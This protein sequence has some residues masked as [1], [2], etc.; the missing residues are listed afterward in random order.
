MRCGSGAGLFTYKLSDKPFD[1]NLYLRVDGE[2]KKHCDGADRT[3][4]HSGDGAKCALKWSDESKRCGD[5]V[6]LL[7]QTD[8]YDFFLGT[9]TKKFPSPRQC[10]KCFGTTKNHKTRVTICKKLD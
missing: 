2:W 9:L 10:D 6:C 4:T 8:I 3:F 7:D 5:F 1:K